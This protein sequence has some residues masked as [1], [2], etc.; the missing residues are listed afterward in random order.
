MSLFWQQMPFVDDDV[1]CRSRHSKEKDLSL[2][3][4]LVSLPTDATFNLVC[5]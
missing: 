5:L 1:K 4:W 2:F 3:K